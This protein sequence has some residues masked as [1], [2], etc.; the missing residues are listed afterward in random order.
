MFATF[1][2]IQQAKKISQAEKTI[3]KRP[4]FSGGIKNH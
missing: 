3:N 4:L 1:G 2:I